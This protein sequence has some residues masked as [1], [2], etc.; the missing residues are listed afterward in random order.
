[1]RAETAEMIDIS[2]GDG[3]EARED[4][5]QKHIVVQVARRLFQAQGFGRTTYS[6]IAK[7]MGISAQQVKDYFPDLEDVCH[8]VISDYLDQQADA[9]EGFSRES[10]PRQRLSL[11]LDSFSA[12]AENLITEGCPMTNLYMDVKRGNA[13][14]ADHAAKLLQHRLNWTKQQFVLITRVAEVSDQPERLVSALHGIIIMAQVTGDTRLIRSQII[15]LKSW[16]RSM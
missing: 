9:F 14:L 10:N 4:R 3:N 1:M 2:S 13:A 12:D 5:H 11:Y 8:A 15:Q 6:D 16:I 7:A